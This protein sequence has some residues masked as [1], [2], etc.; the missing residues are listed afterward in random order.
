LFA[1][2]FINLRN[3]DCLTQTSG[4]W[5]HRRDRVKAEQYTTKYSWSYMAS[6]NKTG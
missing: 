2:N 4:H 5:S 6:A 1:I 3:T